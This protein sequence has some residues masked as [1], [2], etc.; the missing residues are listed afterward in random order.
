MIKLN[1]N[2][3]PNKN[4]NYRAINYEILGRYA[5]N[6]YIKIRRLYSKYCGLSASYIYPTNG[7]QEA[8]L[9][10]FRSFGGP[11]KKCLLIEPHYSGYLDFLAISKTNIIKAH[12]KKILLQSS[13]YFDSTFIL[14]SILKHDPDMIV[15][16][17]LNNPTGHFVEKSLLKK[18]RKVSDCLII[19]D[20]AYIDFKFDKSL[21]GWV[22]EDKGV[23]VLRSMSKAFGLAGCRIGFVI[24]NPKIVSDIKAVLPKG[25]VNN[26]TQFYGCEVLRKIKFIKG[27]INEVLKVKE[28]FIVYL[29]KNSSIRIVDTCANFALLK[30]L[31]PRHIKN[32]KHEK[33][34]IREC[35]GIMKGYFRVSIGESD[36]M[37]KLAI[38]L[39]S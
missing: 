5:Q 39:C 29:K 19:V 22:T 7:S 20:E 14:K 23:T 15:V 31:E 13:C 4:L 30:D 26:I 27:K 18:I 3:L 11:G 38:K 8:L 1:K 34:L 33:I 28:R 37:S 10:I 24:A 9:S 16:N 35:E 12:D 17:N 32:L 25:H 36:E 2:E 6:K 21:I